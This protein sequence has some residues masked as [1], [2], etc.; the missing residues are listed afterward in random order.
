[1]HHLRKKIPLLI[2]ISILLFFVGIA[3]Y[4]FGY[5]TPSYETPGSIV[6]QTSSEN[7]NTPNESVSIAT[8]Q[9]GSIVTSPLIVQGQATGTWFFEAALPIQIVDGNGKVIGKGVAS[10]QADWMTENLVPF[11][12][13]IEFTAPNTPT[14]WIV[15]KKNNPSGL[16]EH[17]DEFRIPVRFE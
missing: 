10:A 4:I 12:G 5:L 7:L 15:F 11:A 8:P 17:D 6:S 13:S 9:P 1:M 2:V 16:P 3:V 14:G